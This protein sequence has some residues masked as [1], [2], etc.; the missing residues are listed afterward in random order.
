MPYVTADTLRHALRDL[1]GTAHHYLKVWLTLKQMG[2]E[3]SKPVE[4]D[5]SNSTEAL[6][7]LFA[8]GHSDGQFYVPFAQ[9]GRFLTMAS[10]ASRSIVQTTLKKW[11]DKTITGTDPTTYL[12]IQATPQLTYRVEPTRIY[13]EGLG[14]GLDGFAAEANAR[15]TVPLVAFGVWYYRQ[16]QIPEDAEPLTYFRESLKRDL[17]LSQPEFQLVFGGASP[18]WDLTFQDQP[19]TEAEVYEAVTAATEAGGQAREFI[20]QTAD[21]YDTQVRAMMTPTE[22]RPR[23]LLED[24]KALLARKLEEGT[25]AIVLYGPPRTG[26]TK[27]VLDLLEEQ[28]GERIQIHDGWGYDELMVGLRPQPGGAWDYSVGPLLKAIRDGKQYIVLEEINRTDFSQA[29]GEVFSLIEEAYRGDTHAITLR[30]GDPFFIPP[31]TIVICTMNTLDRSTEDVDD[32]LLGRMDA[33]EFPP[34][35]EDLS[36]MLDERGLSETQKGKWREL[37]ALIQKHHSMGHGY[38]APLSSTSNSLDFYRTRLRPVLQKHLAGYK[39]AG[40]RTI[41]EK[42]DQLFSAAS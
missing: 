21:E 36:E 19:L 12:D 20:V 23:W 38:F 10:D 1:R 39:E 17:H 32:A 25:K 33:V 30:D 31:E 7:R 9:Q 41:D 40:L 18:S 24:P 37:F 4:V 27:A 35:V 14:H 3:V 28:D 13:P 42:A 34:R 2:L 6:Q 8:Y 15:L 29:I 26:K 11:R 5:T 16:A 22:G